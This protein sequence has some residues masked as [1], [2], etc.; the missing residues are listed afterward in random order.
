M[1]PADALAFAASLPRQIGEIVAFYAVAET[2]VGVVL[3]C[4]LVGDTSLLHRACGALGFS[5]RRIGSLLATKDIMGELLTAVARDGHAEMLEWI[6][7]RRAPR[8]GAETAC[9]IV[10]AMRAGHTN[11][12]KLLAA[13]DIYTVMAAIKALETDPV[14]DTFIKEVVPA[15]DHVLECL[16]HTGK[17]ELAGWWAANRET[18]QSAIATLSRFAVRSPQGAID[19]AERANRFASAFS[20]SSSFA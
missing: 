20:P 3:Q 19:V 13:N 7:A 9:G 6:L 11:C 15:G 12:A 1:Q 18:T 14:L 17:R 8:P 2:R 5:R 16:L 10:A 4:M